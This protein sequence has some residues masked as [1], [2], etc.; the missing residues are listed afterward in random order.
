MRACVACAPAPFV[1][2][3]RCRVTR[4][5]HPLSAPRQR[6][7]FAVHARA[8]AR[9]MPRARAHLR[10]GGPA[11]QHSRLGGDR[12]QG[13]GATPP[14]D[15]CLFG[16]TQCVFE[17]GGQGAAAARA[18][19]SRPR[20]CSV[21]GTQRQAAATSGASGRRQWRAASGGR[22]RQA[23]ARRAAERWAVAG[24]QRDGRQAARTQ[25]ARAQAARALARRVLLLRLLHDAPGQDMPR[26]RICPGTLMPRDRYAPE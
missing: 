25:A 1:P 18:G 7:A 13:A 21:A 19:G 5:A 23:A 4:L 12:V 8:L 2:A 11:G 22:G 26:D 6:R 20:D 17:N 24:R 15:C 16:C 9:M 3:E 10:L 14:A